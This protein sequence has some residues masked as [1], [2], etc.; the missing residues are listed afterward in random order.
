MESARLEVS[1]PQTLAEVGL[2]LELLLNAIGT[3]FK[4]SDYAAP[5]IGGP[6]QTLQL[7]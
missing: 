4:I 5:Y 6:V 7:P 2:V 1:A 3:L